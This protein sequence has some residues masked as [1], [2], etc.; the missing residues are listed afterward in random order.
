MAYVT[1]SSKYKEATL[2]IFKEISEANP[3]LDFDVMY[4][5]SKRALKLHIESLNF[6]EKIWA[7]RIPYEKAEASLVAQ[8]DDFPKSIC[9][10]A[11]SAAYVQSR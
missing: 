9:V 10:K 4:Q 3:K 1:A 8:F 7:G 5:V 6:A 2:A 11:L